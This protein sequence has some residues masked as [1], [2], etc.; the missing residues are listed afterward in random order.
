MG[1]FFSGEDIDELKINCP[2]YNQYL[3]VIVNNR[4]EI[5][6]KVAFLVETI[7]NK[8]SFNRFKNSLGILK[9][10]VVEEETVSEH[11]M[12]TIDLEVLIPEQVDTISEFFKNRVNT[13]IEKADKKVVTGYPATQYYSEFEDCYD[14]MGRYIPYAERKKDKRKDRE[15][16]KS[17][18][19]IPISKGGVEFSGIKKDCALMITY[20]LSDG[21]VMSSKSGDLYRI[22]E[23]YNY[24]G[25][26]VD[27]VDLAKL[28]VE[29]AK[30]AYELILGSDL[31]SETARNFTRSLSQFME[32][33]VLINSY[34]FLRLD[35]VGELYKFINTELVHVRN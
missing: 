23:E 29:N 2:N 34:T 19:I 22:I 1:V 25:V 13:V 35:L 15:W 31:N 5:V 6:A 12:Y 32:D 14:E 11:H 16:K 30:E 33:N 18:P 4:T 8:K 3:S 28:I 20:L 9:N 17:T 24:K 26:G 7:V 10:T 21:K 27:K